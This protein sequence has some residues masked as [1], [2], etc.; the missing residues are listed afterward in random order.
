MKHKRAEGHV[1]NRVTIHF[2]LIRKT[3]ATQQ[4]TLAQHDHRHLDAS[5][6]EVLGSEDKPYLWGGGVA[7]TGPIGP[8][9]LQ[10]LH[11]TVAFILHVLASV[12][13]H[14][15]A[16]RHSKVTSHTEVSAHL[17]SLTLPGKAE[18]VVSLT[19]QCSYSS[20]IV[21]VGDKKPQPELG[22]PELL[23]DC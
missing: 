11:R 18:S 16:A 21:H 15:E 20:T 17:S 8:L 10:L 2:L 19:S 13:S 5:L 12:F 23:G 14:Q 1:W 9:N 4:R 7:R 22:T 3:V 6:V